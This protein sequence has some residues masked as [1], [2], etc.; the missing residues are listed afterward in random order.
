MNLFEQV[1]L[2]YNEAKKLMNLEED[3]DNILKYPKNEIIIHY[4]IVMDN[5]KI[6]IIKG[7]RV[8]YN[9]ILGPYKGGIRISDDIYLDEIKS[10]AF[11]MT[12]KCSLQQLP[13]GGGKGGIKINPS[14]YSKGELEKIARGY[15]NNMF[16]YFGEDKDIPAPD[17]GSNSQ[18]MDWMIDAHQKKENTHNIGIYT[19]KSVECGG[20]EGRNQATGFGL[21]KCVEVWSKINKINL[22]K[23]T[24]I[25]QGFGNVGSNTAYYLNLLGLK[26]IGVC[27][28]T[29]S[30]YFNE[31]VD[32]LD[33]IKYYK[34]HKSLKDYTN[35]ADIEN[36]FSIDCDIIVPCAKESVITE[37]NVNTINCKVIVEGANGPVDF[38]AEKILE[39]KNIEIIPD[40]LANS[41]GVVVSYYEWLQN[42]RSEYWTEEKVLE[43]LSNKME[44]I[45]TK[46]YNE[47]CKKHLTLRQTC[48]VLSIERIKVRAD[49]KNIYLKN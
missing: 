41:G 11:W 43:K 25:I 18:I 10:L 27:D 8:Q 23:S 35:G 6:K 26:C 7:Y 32:I 31:G 3:F 5:N 4:P 15:A 1:E 36:F 44:D 24:Y 20:S 14:N 17:L 16:N 37:Q 9:N 12:L 46:C 39:K 42:K 30:L 47:M 2:Q 48:Y 49:K 34:E 29:R 13:F 28:H 38:K 33:L 19:G 40:I 21:S 22:N 45:Y